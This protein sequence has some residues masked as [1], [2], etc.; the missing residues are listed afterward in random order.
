MD[1][2]S[3]GIPPIFRGEMQVSNSALRAGRIIFTTL[4]P[5]SDPCGFGGTSWL[6]E[7]DAISGARLKDPPFDFNNDGLFTTADQV[8]VILPDG[9]TVYVSP[10]G[11]QSEVGITQG[12]G[13]LFDPG[14]GASGGK[15]YKYLSGSTESASG[16]NLQR[17]VENPGPNSTGRQS[18][19]QL[20]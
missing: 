15:E 7:M 13:I 20:K 16:S 17:V 14:T 8:P 9:S 1:L 3:P 19:R 4:I 12:P 10:S 5:D 11:R 6:M 18:W 2:L